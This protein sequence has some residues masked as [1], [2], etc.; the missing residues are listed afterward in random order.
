M[1]ASLRSKKSRNIL[2]Q[3]ARI[4]PP[5][6]DTK[7]LL[8]EI[9]AFIKQNGMTNFVDEVRRQKVWPQVYDNLR[10]LS[11]HEHDD[12]FR[13]FS[14]ISN[15]REKIWMTEYS[16]MIFKIYNLLEDLGEPVM[17]FKGGALLGFY[18]DSAPRWLQDLDIFLP[19][20]RT[21]WKTLSKLHDHGYE[22]DRRS[23][24]VLQR[25]HEMKGGEQK[26]FINGGAVLVPADKHKELELDVKLG[27][28]SQNVSCDVFG[29]SKPLEGNWKHLFYPSP[30]DSL[31]LIIAHTVIHGVLRLRDINDIWLL[32]HKY[33]HEID[34]DYILYHAQNSCISSCLRHALGILE[35]V[36]GRQSAISEWKKAL[37]CSF[38]SRCSNQI[39]FGLSINGSL[40]KVRDA[41][42][43]STSLGLL[44]PLSID[45]E[46]RR[47]I[48]FRLHAI[49][50]SLLP[51][52]GKI[53]NRICISLAL[54]KHVGS[55]GEPFLLALTPIVLTNGQQVLQPENSCPIEISENLKGDQYTVTYLEDIN[56]TFIW[57]KKFALVIV[58]YFI[59][60]IKPPLKSVRQKDII[61]QTAVSLLTRLINK[62]ALKLRSVNK[63]AKY[64]INP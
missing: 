29:R 18:P 30:D 7:R 49:H 60:I 53:T 25:T 4:A 59:F 21:S 44:I 15:D 12:T 36:Y 35:N 54:K 32:L 10:V 23:N 39:F 51:L 5:S 46:T 41:L 11:E 58:P 37:S 64:I 45:P 52:V 47:L 57:G 26:L 34:R 14:L 19:N 2:G 42:R 24:V 20:A 8:S 55:R 50:Y 38:I 63:M 3:L 56:L 22:F 16:R 28:F 17:I 13:R 43:L 27:R 9:D 62:K 6:G 31:L 48:Y 61:S 40:P 1:F 33:G